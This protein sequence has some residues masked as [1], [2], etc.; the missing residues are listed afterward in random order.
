[1]KAGT[2]Y[3]GDLCYVMTDEEWDE[4]FGLT[5]PTPYDMVDGEF[6]LKDGRRV[7]QYG[8]A[9]GDGQYDSNIGT[10]HC[11]DSGS[12]GCIAIEDIRDEAIE[13]KDIQSFGAVVT[14]EEDFHTSGSASYLVFGHVVIDTSYEE[15]EEYED[16]D[17]WYVDDYVDEE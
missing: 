5:F 2:Y 12:I 7:T 14:F 17:D 4:I 9:Y 8:T 6:E 13:I 16:E 1:M 10:S 3:I 15:E 11:V